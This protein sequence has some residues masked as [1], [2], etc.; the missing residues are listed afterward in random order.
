MRP[1]RPAAAKAA[2]AHLQRVLRATSPKSLR[3][4]LERPLVLS[5]LLLS[6]AILTLNV[7]E[8]R[9]R[10][11]S[12]SSLVTRS[13][14]TAAEGILAE[15]IRR[16]DELV[17]SL[18]DVVA[19]RTVLAAEGSE[20]GNRV[21][22]GSADDDVSREA[23]IR[24]LMV[25]L[26]ATS[27]F[28]RRVSVQRPS[29]EVLVQGSVQDGGRDATLDEPILAPWKT[30]GESMARPEFDRAVFWSRPI[31]PDTGRP[32]LSVID[33]LAG[34]DGRPIV[35]RVDLGLDAFSSFAALRPSVEGALTFV[36][37]QDG[38]FIGLPSG[39]LFPTLPDRDAVL[40][41]RAEDI[42]VPLLRDASRA[43]RGDGGDPDDESLDNVSADVAAARVL[44]EDDPVRFASEGSMYWSDARTVL[45]N[46]DRFLYLAVI[47]PE[48]SLLGETRFARYI[49]IGLS[50]FAI[51]FTVFSIRR[52]ARSVSSPL[53][54]LARQT[55]RVSRGDLEGSLDL[56]S[57]VAEVRLLAHAHDRMRSGLRTL[58]KLK[59]EL[60]IARSIQVS[61]FPAALPDLPEYMIAAMSDAA[62]ETGGDTYDVIG[63]AHERIIDEAGGE[64]E[65][66][67]ITDSD[68]DGVIMMLADATGHGIGPA[69][70]SMQVRSMVRMGARSGLPLSIIAEQC[71]R[72]LRADLPPAHFITAWFAELD[73]RTH[74]LAIFSAGQGPTWRWH[75]ADGRMERLP[76]NEPPLGVR[77]PGPVGRMSIAPL[78]P[79][80]I[81]AILSDGF[82]EAMNDTRAMFGMDQIEA[83]LRDNADASPDAILELID[84]AVMRHVGDRPFGDD[85]TAIIIKRVTS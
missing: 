20:P 57:D 67:R 47:V 10:V 1:I 85:R 69:L 80:D 62:D 64:I 49:V 23:D 11:G 61:T 50:A 55:D 8:S 79:G 24:A 15:R 70:T 53:E 5:I 65:R 41:Q 6:A 40:F 17:R 44:V 54:L 19:A 22:N 76:A 59:D 56:E 3:A 68:P 21:S 18:S 38:R 46:E 12:L 83:I 30:A 66:R 63:I 82:A 26:L 58:L 60:R 25:E 77:E 71:D 43:M 39:T 72:Q 7:L 35:T 4:R 36:L 2:A 28:V 73:A 51:L 33:R 42:D 37:S 34:R 75:A 52:L 29:G 81:V 16:L 9:R 14:L 74:L 78:E 32:Y 45:I 27:P 48:S 84:A 31:I 13:D